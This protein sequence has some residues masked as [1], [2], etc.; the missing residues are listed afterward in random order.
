MNCRVAAALFAATIGVLGSGNSVWADQT[1]DPLVV[2]SVRDQRGYPIAG[3]M[4]RGVARVAVPPAFT[5][6]DGTFSLAAPGIAAVNVS[7]DYCRPATFAVPADAPVVAIVHR[8]DA[9]LSDGPSPDDIASLP[10]AHAESVLALRPFTVLEDSRN[11][12]P[13]PRVSDRGLASQGGL[14]LDAGIPNYDIAANV[15]TFPT[16]PAFDAAQVDFSPPSEAFRYGDQAGGGIFVTQP[17]SENRSEA[18]FVGGSD[19][20]YRLSGSDDASA[21]VMAF[22]KTALESRRRIDAATSLSLGGDTLA[23]NA[24]DAR[25]SLQTDFGSGIAESFSGVR[26]T[27]ERLRERMVHAAM[28]IDRGSYAATRQ[29][30]PFGAGWSDLAAQAGVATLGAS[31]AFF[32]AGFRTS[33][34][35]YDAERI[36]LPRVGATLAQAHA[37]A[38]IH[39]SNAQYEVTAGLGAFTAAYNGGIFGFAQPMRAAIVA[40]SLRAVLWPGAHLSADVTVATTFRLPTFLE[41]YGYGADESALTFDRQALEVATLAYSDRKRFRAEL[42][43]AGERVTG[44]DNG[45]ISASGLAVDWQLAPEVTLRA[46]NM[47]VDDRTRPYERFPRFGATPRPA[48][49]GSV[50]LTFENDAAFRLDAI[51]RSDLI[52]YRPDQHIDASA[53]AP[54]GRGLR[55]YVGTERRHGARYMDAGIRFS[56]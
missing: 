2:G 21:F 55:W 7:C 17:Q 19:S 47:R 3:A 30:T 26:A 41:A 1:L 23:V 50:W 4:V 35:F 37:D 29:F 28:V 34:G 38:G 27:Y 45:R 31:N 40:P 39:L 10:Y 20:A 8:Y 13:G 54:L 46:W 36:G 53:S 15:T 44:L 52:D 56:R 14:L 22:S 5:G 32:D 24:S 9:L 42:T 33:A 51:Y 16:I 49:V 25:G 48:T 18:A 6:D 12:V 43:S 11:V